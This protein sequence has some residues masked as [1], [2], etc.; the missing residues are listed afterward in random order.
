MNSYEVTV[1]V[2]NRDAESLKEKVI[3]ILQK[4][5]TQIIKEDHWGTK[6]LA[7]EIA[8]DSEGYYMFMI[9]DIPPESIKSIIGEF[10]LSSDILRHLFVKIPKA[11]SA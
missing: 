11:K 5:G 8:G 10:R 3:G 4:F 7:Y 9:A 2:R 1:I 6:K